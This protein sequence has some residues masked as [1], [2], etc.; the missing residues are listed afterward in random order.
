MTEQQQQVYNLTYKCLMEW[1]L[2]ML[3]QGLLLPIILLCIVP[4]QH[5]AP[6]ASFSSSLC[7][8]S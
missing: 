6:E 4:E 1:L 7:Q 8:G 3:I 5:L 2:H